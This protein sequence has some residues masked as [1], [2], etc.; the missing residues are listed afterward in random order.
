M[1]KIASATKNLRKS[2]R[3]RTRNVAKKKTL[4]DAVAA[5]RKHVAGGNRAEAAT[6]FR[7]VSQALDK[8]AKTHVIAKG[9]AARKKS[10]FQR[11]LS[12]FAS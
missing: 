6:A 10:R 11:L 12:S 9:T 2:A 5:F 1:P 8:A 4:R 3:N 7:Q